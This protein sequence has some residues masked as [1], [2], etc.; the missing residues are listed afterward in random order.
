MVGG[1]AAARSLLLD[2]PR[3]YAAPCCM[4]GMT[5]RHLARST[6]LRE[7][8][9][10]LGH[11]L[12]GVADRGDDGHHRGRASV[13]AQRRLT[14]TSTLPLP[15]TN[16]EPT[17]LT[18]LTITD[19]QNADQKPATCMPGSIHATNPTMPA[20]ITSKNKPRVMMVI[21]SVSNMA[22]GRTME[23]TIPS[24]TPAR[25]KV[26][27]VSIETPWTQ[28][29][30]THKPS[31]TMHARIRNPSMCVSPGAACHA[32]RATIN[33]VEAAPSCHAL[34]ATIN[35]PMRPQPMVAR[36]ASIRS[37]A[38]TIPLRRQ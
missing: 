33:G 6:S 27:G 24:S 21:G 5:A 34:R 1:A 10:G 36:G 14:M 4:G 23:L 35:G 17:K 20:L 32:L 16:H 8:H 19:V 26:A 29:V 18:R 22:M 25:I 2:F 7:A 3:R 15:P 31:A 11:W 9:A 30:A 12:S 28:T 38:S 37:R 13:G